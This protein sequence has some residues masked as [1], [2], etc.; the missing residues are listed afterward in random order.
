MT[1]TITPAP[2]AQV[3]RSDPRLRLEDYKQALRFWLHYPHAA[4]ARI[5][6]LEN[7]GAD[8]SELHGITAHENPFAKD[9]EILSVP[10]NVIPEGTNY[11]YTEMALLD[12]GLSQSRLRH[13]TTH[14]VKVT[15]RLTF[16]MIGRALD[17]TQKPFDALVDFRKLGFPRRGFDAST[18]IFVVSHIF[19]DA[20]LRDSR[21][22]MNS[23]DVRLLEHLIAYKISPYRGQPGIHLRFPI[24]V[25]PVGVSGFSARSYNSPK[26]LIPRLIRASL[27]RLA[28]NFWFL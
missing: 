24:N 15:G 22:E 13:L 18:Q 25:E 19:Y 7:S 21:K 23:S 27:R 12:K 8:L 5:L 10:G 16:P 6:L 4:A 2:N 3:K 11:G 26:L 17:L 14:M 28:P 9:V 1:A 20:V